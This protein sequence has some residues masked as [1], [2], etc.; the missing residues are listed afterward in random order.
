MANVMANGIG[1]GMGNE[2]RFSC[3]P[4]P[5]SEMPAHARPRAMA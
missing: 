5:G 2:H 4:L 1:N 3:L